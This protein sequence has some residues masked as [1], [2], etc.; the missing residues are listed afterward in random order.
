[1]NKNE[2]KRA[3]LEYC[4]KKLRT[5]SPDKDIAA[6]VKERKERQLKIINDKSREGFEVSLKTFEIVL[7]KFGT[8]ETKIYLF[9]L[10]T[11]DK[12]EESIFNI[13][14]KIIEGREV[15]DSFRKTFLILI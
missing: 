15:H 12:Y 14:E 2:I 3:S 6:I 13:Y 5:D 1:M 11:V 7:V 8:K 10:K 4:V 9:L